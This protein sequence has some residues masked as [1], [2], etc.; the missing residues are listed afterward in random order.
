M[1]F[2]EYLNESEDVLQEGFDKEFTK[3]NLRVH[4]LINQANRK[5]MLDYAKEVQEAVADSKGLAWKAKQM[6]SFLIQLREQ[7]KKIEVMAKELENFSSLLLSMI[8]FYQLQQLIVS[9]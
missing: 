8:I 3:F 5:V 9:L 1:G 7:S 6:R 2:K 4:Q